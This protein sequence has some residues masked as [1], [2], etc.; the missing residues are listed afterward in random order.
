M[1]VALPQVPLDWLFPIK[2]PT[3]ALV[4][5]LEL[6][7]VA[8]RHCSRLKEFEPWLDIGTPG[9]QSF[10]LLPV[11]LAGDQIAVLLSD[12][13]PLIIIAIVPGVP[14]RRFVMLF[15]VPERSRWLFLFIYFFWRAREFWNHTWVTRFDRP[16]SAAIRSK[17]WPS[18]LESNWKF[19]CNTESWSSVKVVRTR[20]VLEDDPPETLLLLLAARVAV[21][22]KLPTAAFVVLRFVSPC[23]GA[24]VPFCWTELSLL[25][26][27]FDTF[28]PGLPDRSRSE[29]HASELGIGS[30]N[31]EQYYY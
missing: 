4:P 7:T 1:C 29:S 2:L 28:S 22:V 8:L 10:T 21:G 13:P 9:R 25:M 5:H 12:L 3:W 23:D 6:M 20:L 26:V 27:P 30:S 15:T 14:G 17:S 16:V 24:G 19:A 18:G 11:L 31:A